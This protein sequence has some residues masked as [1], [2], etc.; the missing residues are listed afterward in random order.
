MLPSSLV[1]VYQEYKKDT[2][3]VA[4]WLAST[5]KACGCPADLV[6]IPPP[7]P[8]QPKTSGRPKGKARKEGKKKGKAPSKAVPQIATTYV[9]AIK[10]FI[11]L[12]ECISASKDPVIS[13]PDAF[14]K[15]I[16]RVIAVRSNF[17][18]KLSQHGVEANVQSDVRHSYFVG[19]LEKVREVLKPLVSTAASASS[20]SSDPIETLNKFNGLKVYEP[21]EAFLNAPDIERPGKTGQDNIIYEAEPPQSLEDALV[22][23]WM[24]LDDLTK[25]RD[26]I[27]NIWSDF[28]D[29]TADNFLDPAAVAV[30][31][32]TGID[33]ARILIENASPVFEDYGGAHGV[34]QEYFARVLV[35]R[36]YSVE[37]IRAWTQGDTKHDF[38]N[39]ASGCYF[40]AGSIVETL[41]RLPFKDYIPIYPDGAFGVYDSASDWEAKTGHEKFKEDEIIIT[42]LFMEALTIVHHVPDFPVVDEFIRGVKEF[43][44][45]QKVPFYL[46][47]AAEMTPT[48]ITDSEA[49]LKL[50]SLLFW[51]D[52]RA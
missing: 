18:E 1:S 19:V 14:F 46:I 22:V 37:E 28:V 34:C 44:E 30:A 20:D 8:K 40:N 52:C 26:F 51:N 6:S 45:T 4:S 2:N 48:Y 9:I 16:N 23:F 42:E 47:F 27:S 5:A 17:G 36:G 32:N 43:H 24:M 25:I 35:E 38:Y 10:N 33:F 29:E 21:S 49:T 11:P 13:I 39:L 41:A 7:P 12:A 31:T 3:S 50:Q 15:A